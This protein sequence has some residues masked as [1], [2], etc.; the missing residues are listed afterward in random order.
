[1]KFI[2]SKNKGT[3]LGDEMPASYTGN[4]ADLI[5]AGSVKSNGSARNMAPV[6]GPA[7]PSAAPANISGMRK[8]RSVAVLPVKCRRVS[9]D[10]SD[11]ML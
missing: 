3:P 11:C 2:P 9:R 5:R 7:H 4:S 1:M 8:H 6:D 10:A